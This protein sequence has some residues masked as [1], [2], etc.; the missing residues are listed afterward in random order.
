M[1]THQSRIC[2]RM[3]TPQ[4]HRGVIVF[5][6]LPFL[7]GSV[8][9]GGAAVISAHEPSKPIIQGKATS[10]PGE[11]ASDHTQARNNPT[12]ALAQT[13]VGKPYQPVYRN[14]GYFGGTNAAD[15]D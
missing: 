11:K 5:A 14:G 15:Q 9:V 7:I 10:D 4:A 12:S 6:A 13:A 3:S 2:P 1:N 8:L